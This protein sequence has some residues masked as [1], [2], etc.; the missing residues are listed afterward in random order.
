VVSI[1]EAVVYAAASFLFG[2]T[3]KMVLNDNFTGTT[4]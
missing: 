3:K 2:S 1:G 4:N